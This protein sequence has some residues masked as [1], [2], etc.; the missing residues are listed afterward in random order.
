[1]ALGNLPPK[2]DANF[3]LAL[4]KIELHAHLTGSIT[5][6]TLH[7][8]WLQH[9]SSNPD[10]PLEDPLDAMSGKSYDIATFFPL[11]SSYIYELCSTRAAVVYSTNAVLNDFKDDGV[12]YL[13]LRTTPRATRDLGKEEYVR[14]VLGCID[15]F[16]GKG[17]MRTNLILSVDRRNTEG[18]ALEVVDL[19]IKFRAEGVVGVDLCGDPC[20]GKVSI[21]RGAFAKA[22]EG[23]LKVTLHFGEVLASSSVR[24]LETLLSFGPDRLGH[25]IHVPEDVRAEVISRGIGVELCVSC[26]VQ[27]KLTQGGVEDHHFGTWRDNGIPVV[28]CVSEELDLLH[29]RLIGSQTDDVGVFGSTLSNE[30]LLVASAFNLSR[31]DLLDLSRRAVDCIFGGEAEKQRLRSTLNAFEQQDSS[32]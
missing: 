17:V 19:A 14:T 24:E 29:A 27:A 23:G 1:M 9:R 15:A 25:V 4:P 30:Y 13:E 21:F 6:T 32:R 22:R 5:P 28:L 20:R 18:E 10:T 12:V 7:E 2:P 26:N 11:F 3:T 16:Q 31:E 8:I